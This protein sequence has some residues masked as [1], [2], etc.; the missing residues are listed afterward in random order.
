MAGSN[1]ETRGR[2]CDGLG[3]ILVPLLPFMDKLLQ[4]IYVDKLGKQVH[5]VIQMLLLNN[6]AVFQDDNAPIHTAGTVQ[7]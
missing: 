3:R 7:S 1:D 6:N 4:D 5:P 2:F